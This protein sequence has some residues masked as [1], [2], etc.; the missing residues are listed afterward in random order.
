MR[1]GRDTAFMVLVEPG[2]H[3]ACG[4]VVHYTCSR[5]LGIASNWQKDSKDHKYRN[6]RKDCNDDRV[7]FRTSMDTKSWNRL[8]SLWLISAPHKRTGGG[9]QLNSVSLT[10]DTFDLN[11]VD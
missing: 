3:V 11:S 1:P 6:D 2:N 10:G 4:R 8:I 7:L 9:D 5:K